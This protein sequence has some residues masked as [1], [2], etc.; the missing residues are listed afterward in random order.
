MDLVERLESGNREYGEQVFTTADAAREASP[1]LRLAVVACMDTRHVV[2]RVFGLGPGDAN[3]IRTAG[4]VVDDGVLRSLVTA[5]H[6]LDVSSVVVMGHTDCGLRGLGGRREELAG[7]L[8]AN[9]GR[10]LEDGEIEGTLAWLQPFEEPEAMVRSGL[11]RIREHALLP[12]RLVLLGC[13]YDNATG[14]VH[15]VEE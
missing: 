11:G 7:R 4:A 5:V 1:R 10:R 3:V 14:A 15:W 13:V 2:E 8:H 9:T 6:M 12:E